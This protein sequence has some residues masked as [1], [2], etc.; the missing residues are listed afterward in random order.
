ME[1]CFMVHDGDGP[2]PVVRFVE[3]EKVLSGIGG[4]GVARVAVIVVCELEVALRLGKA[5]KL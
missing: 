4:V 2:R 3:V 5:W 1:R